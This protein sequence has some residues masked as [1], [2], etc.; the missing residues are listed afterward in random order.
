MTAYHQDRPAY[1]VT[2]TPPAINAARLVLFLV[3]G[4]AKAEIVRAVLEDPKA[5]SP[6][7]RMCPTDGQLTWLAEAAAADQLKRK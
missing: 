3:T 7:Q 4:V 5:Q 1:R 6:A 2:L